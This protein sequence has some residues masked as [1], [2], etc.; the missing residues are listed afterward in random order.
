MGAAGVVDPVMVPMG[1]SK[2]EDSAVVEVGMFESDVCNL[3][4][5]KESLGAA[6]GGTGCLTTHPGPDLTMVVEGVEG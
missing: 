4:G 1:S 2:V 5:L 3:A 6:D